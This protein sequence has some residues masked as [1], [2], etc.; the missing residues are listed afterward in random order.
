MQEQVGGFT[1]SL[2]KDSKDKKCF[3]G[4]FTTEIWQKWVTGKE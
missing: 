1:G 4:L 3:Y 2:A